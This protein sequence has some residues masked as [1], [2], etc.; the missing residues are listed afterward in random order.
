MQTYGGRT[1][2]LEAAEAAYGLWAIS[3]HQLEAIRLATATEKET[4]E[5]EGKIK[6]THFLTSSL[7]HLTAYPALGYKFSPRTMGT[8]MPRHSSNMDCPILTSFVF[9]AL[10]RPQRLAGD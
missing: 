9:A 2:F 5:M 8:G 7:L 10:L 4:L 6:D 3:A 1:E